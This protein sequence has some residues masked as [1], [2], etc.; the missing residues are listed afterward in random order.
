MSKIP[1]SFRQRTVPSNFTFLYLH[2]VSLMCFYII[3]TQVHVNLIIL[4]ARMQAEL[5]YAL[6]SMMHFMT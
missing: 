4:E 6:R 5:L 1:I 3:L 2:V